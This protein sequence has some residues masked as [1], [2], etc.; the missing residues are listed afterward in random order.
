MIQH[1]EFVRGLIKHIV[2]TVAKAQKSAPSAPQPPA[3]S[4]PQAPAHTSSP[5]RG[6]TMRL[7]DSIQLGIFHFSYSTQEDCA[8]IDQSEIA[9]F[10]HS[11]PDRALAAIGVNTW[12]E[13]AF[14]GRLALGITMGGE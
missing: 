1:M 12:A 14:L 2:G 8:R 3:A 4:S 5:N 10:F 7:I 9:Q 11:L 6:L 13:I